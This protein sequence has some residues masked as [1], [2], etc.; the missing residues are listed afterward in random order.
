MAHT[1]YRLQLENIK[2]DNLLFYIKGITV[3]RTVLTTGQW[4]LLGMVTGVKKC[5]CRFHFQNFCWIKPNRN[6]QIHVLGTHE[7]LPKYTCQARDANFCHSEWFKSVLRVAQNS[8]QTA[9]K[10]LAH[11]CMRCSDFDKACLYHP[12]CPIRLSQLC[13]GHLWICVSLTPMDIPF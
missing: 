9:G 13:L 3:C 2:P 11:T 12:F 4:P 5:L 1:K 10:Q 6:G 7:T 8:W